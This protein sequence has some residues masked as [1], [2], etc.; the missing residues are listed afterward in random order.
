MVYSIEY[1]EYSWFDEC[2]S[3]SIA[4]SISDSQCSFE[5]DQI[6]DV[7]KTDMPREDKEELISGMLGDFLECALPEQ[8]KELETEL[9]PSLLIEV[10]EQG[11]R[12]ESLTEQNLNLTLSIDEKTDEIKELKE[13]AW[14]IFG[15]SLVIGFVVPIVAKKLYTLR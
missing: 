8:K 14:L 15:G 10:I 3:C 13:Q 2:E 12:I 5:L 11:K 6:I 4:L 1:S 7:S 9:L